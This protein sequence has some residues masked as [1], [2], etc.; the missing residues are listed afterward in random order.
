MLSGL[1]ARVD[2]VN[3]NLMLVASG[4]FFT[5]HSLEFKN[6]KLA[7]MYCVII[8]EDSYTV[9]N[10]KTLSLQ[11]FWSKFFIFKKNNQL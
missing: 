8:S 11:T 7:N 1:E 9:M 3:H 4:R 5:G 10:F 6:F 2:L